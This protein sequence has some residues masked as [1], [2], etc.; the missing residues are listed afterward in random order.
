MHNNYNELRTLE[1]LPS[2]IAHIHTELFNL[3]DRLNKF[4][5]IT[6]YHRLLNKLVERTQQD[7]EDMK[8]LLYLAKQDDDIIEYNQP[9]QLVAKE[10][11]SDE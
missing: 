4:G 6:S 7:Y 8:Y 2:K 11:V 9:K 3:Q 1:D 5:K 10:L